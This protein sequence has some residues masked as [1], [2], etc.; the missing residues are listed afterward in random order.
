[1]RRGVYSSAASRLSN[2]SMLA[3]PTFVDA[4]G[5][6]G[7]KPTAPS[8][9]K[10]EQEQSS[11]NFGHSGD[12]LP[13]LPGELGHPSEKRPPG[14]KPERFSMTYAALKR[15]SST[16]LLASVLLTSVL[17]DSVRSA[18]VL[19]TSV[20][21]ASVLLTSVLPASVPPA[22]VPLGFGTARFG[23]AGIGELLRNF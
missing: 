8:G 23:P 6:R 20:L 21:L 18:S 4:Y 22:S 7:C 17:P 14:L 16:V 15:R 2:I 1:M 5:G 12:K 9:R 19:L 3:P 11:R 13:L 10:A